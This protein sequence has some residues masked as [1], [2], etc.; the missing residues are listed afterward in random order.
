[1]QLAKSDYEVGPNCSSNFA[2]ATAPSSE[3]LPLA[4]LSRHGYTD[5]NGGNDVP[6]LK[7]DMGPWSSFQSTVS[8]DYARHEGLGP[9]GSLYRSLSCH[10]WV[11]ARGAFIP[12]NIVSG[13][14]SPLSFRSCIVGLFRGICEDPSCT[15]HKLLVYQGIFDMTKQ[16]PGSCRFPL[17]SRT[18]QDSICFF[19]HC[20]ITNCLSHKP[21]KSRGLFSIHRAPHSDLHP[22]HFPGHSLTLINEVSRRSLRDPSESGDIYAHE[23]YSHSISRATTSKIPP[24]SEASVRNLKRHLF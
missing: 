21:S 7:K 12:G 19:L 20:A 5:S 17:F 2:L 18:Q 4:T 8:G 23:I 9:R 11:Q 13:L 15:H 3:K 10:S 16:I 14:N 22:Q 1:M 6:I 24:S